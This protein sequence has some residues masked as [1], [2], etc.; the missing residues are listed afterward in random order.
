MIMALTLSKKCHVLERRGIY[1]F[2]DK[3]SFV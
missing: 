1:T 2:G 3:V